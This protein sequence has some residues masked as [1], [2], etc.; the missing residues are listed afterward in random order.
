MPAERPVR[1]RQANDGRA[2]RCGG[3]VAGLWLDDLGAENSDAG[4]SR[5]AHVGSTC[6]IP[7]EICNLPTPGSFP[8]CTWKAGVTRSFLLAIARKKP[9]DQHIVSTAREGTRP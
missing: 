6:R 3:A 9:A 5:F 8:G 1:H 4:A 7:V 2:R